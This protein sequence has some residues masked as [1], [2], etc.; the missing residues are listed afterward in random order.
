[1]PF[2]FEV[3]LAASGAS[4]QGVWGA[5]QWQYQRPWP[6]SAARESLAESTDGGDIDTSEELLAVS[7]TPVNDTGTDTGVVDTGQK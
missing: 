4:D 6:T 1:M 2:W 5:F 7:L 3:V